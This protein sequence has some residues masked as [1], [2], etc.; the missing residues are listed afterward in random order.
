MVTKTPIASTI[1][2]QIQ[3]ESRSEP[4]LDPGPL[5]TMASSEAGGGS[6]RGTSTE[7]GESSRVTGGGGR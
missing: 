6:M 7:S 3:V 1:E 2:I 5:R 4:A